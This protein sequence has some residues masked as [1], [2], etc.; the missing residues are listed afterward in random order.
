MLLAA[1]YGALGVG[2]TLTAARHVV[3]HDLDW[4][5]AAILQAEKRVHRLSQTRPVTSAWVLAEDSIDTV[6]A[7]VLL[8]KASHL[9]QTLGQTEGLD[10]VAEVNLREIAGRTAES[11]DDEVRA[12]LDEARGLV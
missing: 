6:I 1:T 3:L 4:T 10:A 9:A 11:F 5:F 8:R 7:R 12:W 2:V